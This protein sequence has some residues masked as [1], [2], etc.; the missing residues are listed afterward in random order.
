VL[1]KKFQY[2]QW[3]LFVILLI[4]GVWSIVSS[5]TYDEGFLLTTFFIGIVQVLASLLFL[6]WNIFEG[7]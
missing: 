7:Y 5:F 2:R 4:I 1:R 3:I 6:K